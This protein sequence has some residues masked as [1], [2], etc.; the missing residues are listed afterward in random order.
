VN[1]QEN[2]QFY[3]YKVL[4]VFN[5]ATVSSSETNFEAIY[6]TTNLHLYQNSILE[7]VLQATSTHLRGLPHPVAT[8]ATPVCYS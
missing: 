7:C 1:K 4:A 2:R 8:V 5:A 3:V 6:V